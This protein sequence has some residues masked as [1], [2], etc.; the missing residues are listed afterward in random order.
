MAQAFHVYIRNNTSRHDAGESSI[1]GYFRQSDAVPYTAHY[2]LGKTPIQD[3]L[4]YR[5]LSR[6]QTIPN[7]RCQQTRT[8]EQRTLLNLLGFLTPNPLILP[9][10]THGQAT[11]PRSR[12][13]N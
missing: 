5:Q 11:T 13:N 4:T 2:P 10:H 8:P 7:V 9:L 1:F 12:P 6:E 3:R